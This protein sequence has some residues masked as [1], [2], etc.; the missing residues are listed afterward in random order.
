[1]PINGVAGA[2]SEAPDLRRRNVDVVGAGEIIRFRRSQ[3]AEAVRQY[4]DD[5]FADN[6][7]LARRELFEDAEHQLLLAHGGGVLDLQFFGKR[8]KL[9]RSLGLEFLQFHFPHRMSYGNWASEVQSWRR[10]LEKFAGLWAGKGLWADKGL[11]PPTRCTGGSSPL[12]PRRNCIRLRWVGWLED[13]KRPH[14]RQGPNCILSWQRVTVRT[15]LPPLR[16]RSP[17]SGSQVS[18]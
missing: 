14:F 7:S 1:M 10:W 4:L 6:V 11:G 13:K 9:R 8:H 18:H 12:E 15:V 3:K 17:P 5:A 16:S 2:Q